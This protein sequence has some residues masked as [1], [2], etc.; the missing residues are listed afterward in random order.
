MDRYT[1]I[2]DETRKR[3]FDLLDERGMSQK[4]FAKRLNVSSQTITDWKKEKSNSF[5]Q[6]LEHI[7]QTLHTTPGWLFFGSGTKDFSEEQRKELEKQERL[8]IVAMNVASNE[9][10]NQVKLYAK[11]ILQQKAKKLGTSFSELLSIE[12]QLAYYLGVTTSELLGE[13]K[14]PTP[15][16]EGEP[17]SPPGYRLLSPANKAI[18]DQMVAILLENQ[19][20]TPVLKVIAAASDGSRPEAAID[21]DPEF[22]LPQSVQALPDEYKGKTGGKASAPEEK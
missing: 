2:Y 9:A 17:L 11:S 15:A 1:K 18:I 3:I 13:E 16:S 19:Q 12:P 10:D 22:K 21:L 14:E 5:M 8:N 20:S 4:E 7:S 6:K